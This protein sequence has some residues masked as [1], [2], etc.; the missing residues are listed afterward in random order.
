VSDVP[1]QWDVRYFEHS[2]L[3]PAWGWLSSEES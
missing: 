2:Q 1:P 3:Q